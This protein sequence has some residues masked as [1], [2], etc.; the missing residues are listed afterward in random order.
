M[1]SQVLIGDQKEFE[2]LKSPENKRS[3]SKAE[4]LASHQSVEGWPQMVRDWPKK[5]EAG[6][7]E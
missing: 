4:R 6:L 2:N 1:V 3:A 7:R 5:G